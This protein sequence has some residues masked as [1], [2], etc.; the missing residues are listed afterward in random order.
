[1]PV[2]SPCETEKEGD[3]ELQIHGLVDTGQ[4]TG[5]SRDTMQGSVN[6]LGLG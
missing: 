4:S 1:M 2:S 3:F 6:L 5:D